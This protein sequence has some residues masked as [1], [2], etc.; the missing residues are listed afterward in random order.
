MNLEP[1][2][3]LC[4]DFDFKDNYN[5][6]I[7]GALDRIMSILCYRIFNMAICTVNFTDNRG[8]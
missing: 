7:N 6:L 3:H 2:S 4:K 8:L 5:Q 1:K